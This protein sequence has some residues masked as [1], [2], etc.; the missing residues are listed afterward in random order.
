[1][2]AS[3]LVVGK[4]SWTA[5]DAERVLWVDYAKGI[6]IALVVL[7][8]VQRGLTTA[9]ILT[10]PWHAS[11]D[12]F[13]Y[14]FHMP[15]FFFLS[16]MLTGRVRPTREVVSG[17]ART[18]LYPYVLWSF[19]QGGINI[20]LQCWTNGGL[21]PGRLLWS[22][23]L[24]P[25][26]QFWFLYVLFVCHVLLQ[27]LNRARIRGWRL[28][29]VGV[30]FGLAAPQLEWSAVLG[31]LAQNFVYFAA[32]VSLARARNR[33]ELVCRNGAIVV[34]APLVLT[35]CVYFDLGG[36]PLMGMGM[37]MVGVAGALA[38]S[39]ALANSGAFPLVRYIGERSLPIYV[40]HIITASGTRI[41]LSKGFDIADPVLHLTLGLL[42]GLAPPLALARAAE[43]LGAPW[44]FQLSRPTENG[45]SRRPHWWDS[46]R[47][48]TRA[49]EVTIGLSESS[50]VVV[51][52]GPPEK[53]GAP[54]AAPSTR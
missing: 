26:G 24:Q 51:A 1:M 2:R 31:N 20:S 18:L 6:G 41:L 48:P 16:G 12:G 52:E 42:A 44:L 50:G 39:M 37:A 9:G 17:K 38:L 32:G 54:D 25:Y 28:L 13:I 21:T 15:L 8:H 7:G 11:V 45:R 22:V 19:F 35:T 47:R 46:H 43:I 27:P 4:G 14:A 36:Y 30:V 33:L 29:A 40:A 10:A 34:V 53:V 5:D 3:G 23:V 49:G